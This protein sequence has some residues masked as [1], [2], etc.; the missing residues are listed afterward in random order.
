[1]DDDDNND[2]ENNNNDNI[3]DYLMGNTRIFRPVHDG[4]NIWKSG[5][6]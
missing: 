1:M 6:S 5:N 4:S 3:H 2:N